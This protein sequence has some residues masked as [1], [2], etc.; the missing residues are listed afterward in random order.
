MLNLA[1]FLDTPIGRGVH[2]LSETLERRGMPPVELN[3][4]GGFALM[5]H[6]MRNA[7]AFTDIDYVGKHLGPEFDQAVNEVGARH[8]LGKGWINNDG[9]FTGSSIEDFEISTG[10]LHFDHAMDVGN[11]RI[12]VLQQP[13]L[14]RMKIISI[15]TSLMAASDGATASFDRS[16]DMSDIKTL[17]EALGRSM[18][19]IRGDYADV[20]R[21]DRT[22]DAI[23]T[24]NAAKDH[25]EGTKAVDGMLK[26]AKE[27]AEPSKEPEGIDKAAEKQTDLGKLISAGRL[28]IGAILNMASA[29]KPSY[30]RKLPTGLG[31]RED[32]DDGT[33]P[34]GPGE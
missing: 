28:D 15:D 22:F 19:D 26:R 14:L 5:M 10:K 25:S 20:V 29:G 23:E 8:K 7:Q 34:S 17:M 11:I 13:D 30:G 18:D 24:Y 4:I 6:S 12:N 31:F 33:G 21:F 1:E 2:D 32:E 27:A 16:K 9:M 3:C